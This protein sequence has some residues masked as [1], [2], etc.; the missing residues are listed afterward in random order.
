MNKAITEFYKSGQTTTSTL[1][2]ML[3]TLKNQVWYYIGLCF[4]VK[5]LLN[6]WHKNAQQ[7]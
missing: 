5:C 2:Q 7:L 4:I 1:K 6:K 3:T